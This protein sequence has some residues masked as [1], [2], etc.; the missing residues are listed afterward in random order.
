MS[1]EYGVPKSVITKAVGGVFVLFALLYAGFNSWEN[2]DASHI[3]VVQAPTSGKLTWYTSAGVKPQFFG[4]VTT[5]KKRHQYEFECNK[6]GGGLATTF[7]DGG[8]G[9]ICGSIAWEMPLDTA[10]LNMLHSKYGSDE[11]ISGQIIRAAVEKAAMMTGPLLSS[12]ESYSARRNE[13][14]FLTLDQISHGVYKADVKE[15]KAKDEMTGTEKT[16]KV[17][18]LI[19]S[20]NI[21]DHGFARQEPSPLD[22]FHLHAFNLTIK[23]IQY[24]ATV[25]KQIQAQQNAIMQVQTAIAQAKQAEQQA[26][27]AEKNGQAE[28]AKAK[29]AQEVEKATAVTLAEQGKD[30][31]ALD[32]QT[33]VLRKQELTLQGEGEAA[34]RRLAMQADG[35]L[36]RKLTAWVEVQKA[37][38]DAIA[39]Y[40]GNWVPGVVMG[41]D[42]KAFGGPSTLIDLLTAKTA[43]DI[44]LDLRVSA[45]AS[46]KPNK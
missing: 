35:A 22:E 34:K 16:V 24:D 41:G 42:G 7:N 11:A 32:V 18:H 21:N 45:A 20:L 1:N 3:M 44:G 19:P 39:K 28:A 25:T 10:D 23:D 2:L 9:A 8:K 33:A 17:V 4:K 6:D 40:Q 43:R 31:A 5:Y 27:T 14:L 29:W 30:V 13:L 46:D 15:E 38:A 12:T 37:Y 36:D 26:I